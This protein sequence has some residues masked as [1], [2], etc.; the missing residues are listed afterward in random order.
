MGRSALEEWYTS[1]G[2][3]Q[4]ASL[5]SSW[6]AVQLASVGNNQLVTGLTEVEIQNAS[7][8]LVV[9]FRPGSQSPPDPVTLNPRDSTSRTRGLLRDVSPPDNLGFRK[10][11]SVTSTTIELDGSS[12]ADDVRYW[13]YNPDPP[14]ADTQWANPVNIGPD[15]SGTTY[16]QGDF[17]MWFDV[18]FTLQNTTGVGQDWALLCVPTKD[19]R[20]GGYPGKLCVNLFERAT[21]PPSGFE[22]L[23]DNSRSVPTN[24]TNGACWHTH[25][26]SEPP[27]D[28]REREMILLA[29]KT[30]AANT[31]KNYQY[32]FHLCNGSGGW[33]YFMFVP[34]GQEGSDPP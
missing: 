28:Y 31:T 24:S 26:N 8:D 5:S 22:K 25:S 13:F 4:T 12:T 23:V 27:D 21:T 30:L 1:T 18:R 11:I 9:A 16:L 3:S 32:T 19:P 20:S 17:E 14:T 2:T 15:S 6:S 34:L 10:T 33:W 7:A 29:K